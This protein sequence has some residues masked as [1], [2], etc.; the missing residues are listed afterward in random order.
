MRVLLAAE[1]EKIRS[2]LVDLLSVWKLAASPSARVRRASWSLRLCDDSPQA[3]D[4]G[5]VA[6]SCTPH[7]RRPT[8]LPS[9]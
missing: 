4:Q 6:A 2:A 5:G 3:K 1:E 7:L 8:P 9:P